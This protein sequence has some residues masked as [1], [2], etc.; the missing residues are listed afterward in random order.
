MSKSHKKPTPVQMKQGEKPMVIN[1][2]ELYH[3]AQPYQPCP[4]RTGGHVTKKDRPRD[5][6]YKRTYRE[7]I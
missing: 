1:M 5:K 4:F 2:T 7:E 3:K 6:S